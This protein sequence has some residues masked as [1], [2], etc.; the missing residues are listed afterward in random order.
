M[1]QPQLAAVVCAPHI[2]RAAAIRRSAVMMACSSRGCM[3]QVLCFSSQTAGTIG[4]RAKC[5]HCMPCLAARTCRACGEA[6]AVQQGQRLA[7]GNRRVLLLGN[8][9]QPGGAEACAKRPDPLLLHPTTQQLPQ[10]HAGCLVRQRRGSSSTCEVPW[11]AGASLH[12]HAC[13]VCTPF[14]GM[15]AA[16]KV[17]RLFEKMF[18]QMSLTCA[19]HRW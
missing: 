17:Q 10:V 15:A 4:S 13:P 14:A 16:I 11:R 6:D 3:Q 9:L 18:H 5:S 8:R 2:D 1:P 12:H 19:V 7:G